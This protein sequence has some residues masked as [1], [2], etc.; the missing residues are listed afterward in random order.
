MNHIHTNCFKAIKKAYKV[1]GSGFHSIL[2]HSWEVVI[3]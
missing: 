1:Y 3:E 2:K